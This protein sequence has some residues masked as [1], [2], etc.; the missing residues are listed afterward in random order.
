[1][2]GKYAKSGGLPERS[3]LV[4]VFKR[5]RPGQGKQRLALQIMNYLRKRPSRSPM[6]LVAPCEISLKDLYPVLPE[7]RIEMCT[8]DLCRVDWINTATCRLLKQTIS[9]YSKIASR[10]ILRRRDSP[11]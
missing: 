3:T 1:M 5:P 4:V 11:I 8:I 2:I 9:I 6:K 10:R 7:I